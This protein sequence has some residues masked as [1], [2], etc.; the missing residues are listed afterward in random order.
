MY[1]KNFKGNRGLIREIILVLV[2]LVILH[3]YFHID[4]IAL[5]ENYVVK[6]IEWVR[7]WFN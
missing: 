3:Y 1:M 7:G 5:I 4:V 2:A 6:A